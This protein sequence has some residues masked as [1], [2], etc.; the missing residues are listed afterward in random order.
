MPL[1]AVVGVVAALVAGASA[2]LLFGCVG[3]ASAAGVCWLWAARLGAD[4]MCA[5]HGGLAYLPYLARHAGDPNFSGGAALVVFGVAVLLA[6]S[7]MSLGVLVCGRLPL[8]VVSPSS[9][10]MAICEPLELSST[11]ACG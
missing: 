4:A 9:G 7:R 1:P 2:A 10:G 3:V 6:L 5:W 11:V 8:T